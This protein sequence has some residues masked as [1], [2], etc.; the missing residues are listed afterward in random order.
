MSL[1]QEIVPYVDGNGLVAPSLVPAGV[2]RGSDNGPMFTSEY[3]IMVHRNN[4][5]DVNTFSNY[6]IEIHKCIGSDGHLHRAPG[7]TSQDEYDDN[8]ATLAGY[9]EFGLSVPFTLPLALCRFPQ[10]VYAYLLSKDVP[11]FLMAPLAILTAFIIGLSNIGT[12]ALDSNDRKLAWHLWQ[13]TKHYSVICNLAG[14]FWYW[15]QKRVYKTQNPMKA[16]AEIYF[17]I[18]HPFVRYWIG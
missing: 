12:P 5:M 2:M 18:G 10:L 1:K 14:K 4:E 6:I 9:A 11:S 17:E 15:R 8:I 13:A 3:I 7:D 16:I